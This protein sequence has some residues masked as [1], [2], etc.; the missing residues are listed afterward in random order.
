MPGNWA[1]WKQKRNRSGKHASMYRAGGKRVLDLVLTVPALLFLAP[2][3][4]AL[5]IMVRLRLGGPVLFCQ[6]R[7]G[8]H[9]KI[10]ILH[11]FRS[12]TDERDESGRLLPDGDRLTPFGRWLRATSFD[13]LPELADVLLGNLSL[14]GPRPLLAAY[15]A[16]YS[17]EQRH[18]L[19]VKPGITGWAQVNGRNALSWDKKFALDLWYVQHQSLSTDLKILRL[20]VLTLLRRQGI[21]QEGHATAEEFLGGTNS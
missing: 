6:E 13:E 12:M 20:T 1:S 11:K 17:Q 14:V 18:R 5:G 9:G 7:A 2:L 8:L 10:F 3:M 15:V 19:D 21:T 4:A 16:R